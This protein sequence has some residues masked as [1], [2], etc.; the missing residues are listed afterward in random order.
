MRRHPNLNLSNQSNRKIHFSFHRRPR[1]A[2]QLNNQRL[3]WRRR[4][5]PAICFPRIAPPRL[6]K[7]LLIPRNSSSSWSMAALVMR[8]LMGLT[9]AWVWVTL[10]RAWVWVTLTRAW[11]WVTLSR[12]WLQVT[13]AKASVQKSSLQSSLR[14]WQSLPLL[15]P[16]RMT[17]K[18]IHHHS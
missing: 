13:L 2:I 6:Q 16:L 14:F 18:Q 7:V 4:L 9:R 12:R 17:V 1:P 3:A 15:K 11:V 5:V 10:T 8:P